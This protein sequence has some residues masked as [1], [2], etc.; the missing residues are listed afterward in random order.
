V[1]DSVRVGVGG[2]KG[3]EGVEVVVGEESVGTSIGT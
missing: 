2:G 1:G 3:D